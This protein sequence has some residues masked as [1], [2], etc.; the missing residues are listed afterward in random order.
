MKHLIFEIKDRIGI[1]RINRPEALNALNREVVSELDETMEMIRDDGD[2]AVLIIGSGDHFA[3]GADI[4]SM[5]ELTAKEAEEFA[6][7]DTFA[8]LANLEIPTIAAVEGFA[9]GGGLELALACDLRIASKTAKMGFPEIKLGI[10]PGAGGTVRVPRM[11]GAGL[12][13]EM[14]F[15]GETIGAERAEQI[16]LVNKV[17]EPECLMDSAMDWAEKLCRKSSIALRT[18]K[19]TIQ[20]GL[21][22]SELDQAVR[23]EQKNWAEM[24][25][26][27]D[28]KEGMRAFIE[29]RMPVYKGI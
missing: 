17:V 14:I 24:F 26:T 2:I 16:G 10:M 21:D 5:A 27:E 13:K 7:T 29:K 15:L 4:K 3:A 1:L 28:Q 19:L 11:I 20:A 23:I 25:D 22:E 6:F 8:K 18:A 9:L 12:A